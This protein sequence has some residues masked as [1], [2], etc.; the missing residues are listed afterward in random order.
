MGQIFGYQDLT[1]RTLYLKLG[2]R[3]V[4]RGIYHAGMFYSAD[5][6][7]YLTQFRA[8]DPVAGRWLS[9]DPIGESSDPAFNVY[10]YVGANPTGW[11]DSRG[12]DG[13]A[14]TQ[15]AHQMIGQPGYGYFDPSEES[16]GRLNDWTGGI[17]SFKCNKFVWDALR[18][19]GDPAGRMPGDRIPS[20]SEWGSTKSKIPGYYVVP[21]GTPLFPGDIISDGHHVGLYDPS[22]PYSRPKTTSAAAPY[23]AGGP[24]E[25]GA[26][27]G[28][29]NND[30]AFRPGQKTVIHRCNCD[31]RP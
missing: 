16:R 2:V 15:W 28:V 19:G 13:V 7:L 30:W 17:G 22:G 18:N 10:A 25:A 24:S 12:L 31:K 26:Q 20:A 27:G 23:W 3:T 4:A 11:I 6:G 9:R 29:I 21:P 8:Y 1:V 14:A 5:S